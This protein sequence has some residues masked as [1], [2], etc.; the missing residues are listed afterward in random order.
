MSSIGS[1]H[2]VGSLH[3]MHSI[4]SVHSQMNSLHRG[5]PPSLIQEAL[6][7]ARAR[8]IATTAALLLQSTTVG[9]EEQAPEAVRAHDI[10]MTAALLLRSTSAGHTSPGLNA[11]QKRVS[12]PPRAGASHAVSHVV[13]GAVAEA[14]Q[15]SSNAKEQLPILQRRR[16][17]GSPESMQLIELRNLGHDHRRAH[18]S[19]PLSS[20]SAGATASV[21]WEPGVANMGCSAVAFSK[22]LHMQH[23]YESMQDDTEECLLTPEEGEASSWNAVPSEAMVQRAREECGSEDWGTHLDDTKAQAAAAKSCKRAREECGSL[24]WGSHLDDLN[25]EGVLSAK[26]ARTDEPAAGPIIK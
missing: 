7:A 14:P 20:S 11:F 26:V 12:S 9:Q 1:C 2:S 5:S 19:S 8:D 10:A 6:D 23:K 24:N 21:D 16:T 13:P 4:H 25:S 22:F 18:A 3:G 15:P 17:S